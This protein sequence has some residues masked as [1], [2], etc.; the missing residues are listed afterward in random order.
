MSNLKKHFV[1]KTNLF[2][3]NKNINFDYKTLIFFTFLLSGI[4]TGVFIS[5][6][7]IGN[8]H[9]FYSEI[10]NTY[11]SHSLNKNPIS[12][13]FRLFLPFV[14]IMI[15]TYITGLCGV[16]APFLPIAPMLLGCTFGIIVTQYYLNY[17]LSGILCCGLIYLP[18]YAI[19]TATLIKCC[20]RCFSI[21]GEI[22]YYIITGKG[23]GKPIL[24][25]Y[26]LQFLI[27][28]LPIA[29]GCVVTVLFYGLFAHLFN[30]IV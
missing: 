13:F 6:K 5:E 11:L 4:I 14:I 30:F 29:V 3:T 1:I 16:G 2:K 15:T 9:T 12:M 23:E 25:E 22:F 19:T 17:G 10:I 8:W 24:K 26:T 28:I 18:S 21:S 20:C 7:G 27:Y